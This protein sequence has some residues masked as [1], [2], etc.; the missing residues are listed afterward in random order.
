MR[1]PPTNLDFKLQIARTWGRLCAA[2]GL[3]NLSP[4][5]ALLLG[6]AI[7]RDSI[8]WPLTRN[9]HYQLR[10]RS[11]VE[12]NWPS[13]FEDLGPEGLAALRQRVLERHPDVVLQKS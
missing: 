7:I 11:S 12:T 8:V 10:K 5:D 4:E 1:I 6:G 2:V 13:L 3:P 9:P